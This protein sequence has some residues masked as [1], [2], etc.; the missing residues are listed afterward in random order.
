[1]DQKRVTS[2]DVAKLAEALELEELQMFEK[3]LSEAIVG[4]LKACVAMQTAGP[5]NNRLMV[6]IQPDSVN[7]LIDIYLLYSR[8]VLRK[9]ATRTSVTTALP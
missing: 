3:V 2:D 1:M 6:K 9:L 8:A 5:G 7:F 4:Y